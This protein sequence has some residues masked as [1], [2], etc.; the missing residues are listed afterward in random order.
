MQWIILVVSN[1]NICIK[2]YALDFHFFNYLYY[3]KL[4]LHIDP[5]VNNWPLMKDLS[6]VMVIVATYYYFVK[7]AGPRLM[8]NRKPF[9]LKRTIQVY[10][11]FQIF[12]CCTLIYGVS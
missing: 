1:I 10:Y 11:I 4:I 6:T 12:S 9:S 8:E 7:I 2:I 5:R 3:I